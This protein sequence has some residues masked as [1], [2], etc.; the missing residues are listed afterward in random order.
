MKIRLPAFAVLVIVFSAAIPGFAAESAVS[1]LYFQNTAKNAE[2]DWLSKGMAD[3]L[4]TDLAGT[5]KLAVVE[6]E[7][8]QK[9]L[10][11]QE[12]ALSGLFDEQGAVK[13]GKMLSA[14]R[15]VMGSFIVMQGTL[16]VDAKLVDVETARVL[17]AVQ[18]T[19][20]LSGLF[21][22]E[23]RLALGLLKEMGVEASGQPASGGTGSVEAAKAYYTGMSLLDS[24]DY[25]KAA[26]QFRQAAVIDPFYLKPQ[27]SLEEAYQFLKDFRRQRWQR[28][29]NDLY[30]KAEGIKRRLSAPKWLSYS[31]FVTESYAKGLSA[32]DIKKLTDA[33]P[34][35]FLCDTRAQ[36]V[37][38][39]QHTLLE[40]GDLAEEYFEDTDTEAA[41][42]REIMNIALQART[43]LKDD[44]FLPEILYMELFGL[45]YFQ[46]WDDLM[47][48]CEHLMTTYPDYRMMWAIE[49]FYERALEKKEGKN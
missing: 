9:L 5:G 21:D 16:R 48:A 25:A 40:I 4:I 3:M 22:V 24:G 6:R 31:E 44:P 37:W 28:E 42:H 45:Q 27:K 39:L 7:E 32:Q 46:R 33:D 29:I 34:S 19:G 49:D 2:L 43:Q 13:I 36:C 1:V 10:K 41:M 20:E 30:V 17:K 11:E 23:K 12:L 18:S 14:S 26:A 38:N 8:L 35:L 15:I 47:K